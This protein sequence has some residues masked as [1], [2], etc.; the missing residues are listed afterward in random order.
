MKLNIVKLNDSKTDIVILV[1]HPPYDSLICLL[2]L[3][4][5]S[6]PCIVSANKKAFE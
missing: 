6:T 4:V 1:S 2:V 3:S 5:L